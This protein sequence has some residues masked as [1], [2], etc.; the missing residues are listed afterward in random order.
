[1]EGFRMKRFSWIFA[2]IMALS[3][4]FIGCPAGD[5]DDGGGSGTTGTTGGGAVYGGGPINFNDTTISWERTNGGD[6]SSPGSVVVASDGLSYKYTYAN[7]ANGGNENIVVRFMVSLPE[8]TWLNDFGSVKFTWQADERKVETDASLGPLAND[9]GRP[10]RTDAN[11]DKKLYLLAAQDES[12]IT[13]YMQKASLSEYVVSTDFYTDGAFSAEFYGATGAVMVNG[14]T[15]QDIEMPIIYS[16]GW[17]RGDIWLSVFMI[18]SSDS[19]NTGG[20]YNISNF[21]LIER[22]NDGAGGVEDVAMGGQNI[23][24]AGPDVPPYS[25]PIIGGEPFD[26]Y[27]D[28]SDWEHRGGKWGWQGNNEHQYADNSIVVPNGDYDEGSEELT[29]AFVLKGQ[30]INF[31]LTN[32]QF[33]SIKGRN[34]SQV[35]FDIYGTVTGTGKI[36]YYFADADA[37]SSWDGTSG[38]GN[39]EITNTVA[40]GLLSTANVT[41]NSNVADE[42]IKWFMIQ[43]VPDDDTEEA[44]LVIEKIHIYTTPVKITVAA[45]D[46]G[47]GSD[48]TTSSIVS[49]GYEVV[50][51]ASGYG[52]FASYVKVTLPVDAKLSDFVF[53]E[54]KIKGVSGDLGYKTPNLN[55]SASVPTGNPNSGT[56]YFGSSAQ[57][58]L[59]EAGPHQLKW[60]IPSSL[61]DSLKDLNVVYLVISL[62]SSV[63]TFDVT[64]IQFR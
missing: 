22:V 42:K 36:R 64:D 38:T 3:I 50:Q 12:D 35:T 44:E 20:S 62:W 26:F 51:T 11:K 24:G 28:L 29:V 55:V 39:L 15:A 16:G 25:P 1:M 31:Q 5:D 2:L 14:V 40:G 57:V 53:I 6:T 45:G 37:T 34:R 47:N 8:G 46:I 27:V 21:Q 41:T 43:Y 61:D 4:G 56:G 18:I 23:T 32:A 10:Y 7:V 63:V 58:N 9:V 48:I 60:T 13:P 19:S 17:L 54:C 52:G 59:D 49:G 33:E 30:R